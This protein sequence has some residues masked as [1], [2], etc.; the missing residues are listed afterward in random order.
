MMQQGTRETPATEPSS[1]TLAR[2]AFFLDF[3]HEIRKHF[4]KVVLMVTGGFRTRAGMEAAISNGACDLIG[5]GR[6][7][8]VNPNIPRM[9]LNEKIP[10][11]DAHLHLEKMEAP[12]LVRALGLRILTAGAETVRGR[13]MQ[14]ISS[15]SLSILTFEN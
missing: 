7:A 10:T 15:L 3:A 2:E 6:P 11:K 4:P 13:S 8:A 1:R 5:L 14:K 9:I 12:F